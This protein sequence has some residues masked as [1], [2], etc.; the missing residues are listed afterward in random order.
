MELTQQTAIVT[1]AGRGIGRAVAM[2]LAGAGVT[3]IVNYR[4]DEQAADA[5]VS[6]IIEQGGQALAICADVSDPEQATEL[7]GQAVAE[8]G[9]LD[10][11]VNNAGITRD[12]LL[13]AFSDNDIT[14]VIAT[15]LLSAI[16]CARAAAPVMM[17]K[18]YGR[19]INISSSAASKPGRGQSNYAAA[20]GGLEAF[21]RAI[22]VE[23]APRNI[24]VNAVAPGVIET[25]MTRELLATAEQE[26]LARLLVKRPGTPAEVARFLVTPENAYV[27]GQV[28]LVDGGLKMP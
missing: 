26:I 9:R 12:N 17:R 19:I 27:T 24:L 6:A 25:G 4:S 1:G 16:Y 7:V 23:L 22:A 13:A 28:F 3:V 21:T 15:N 18:R 2:E 11:L 5:T 14:Q 20:K 8:T 10:I